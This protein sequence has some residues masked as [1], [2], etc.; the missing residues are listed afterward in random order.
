[1]TDYINLG[2]MLTAICLLAGWMVIAARV[3]YLVKMVSATVAVVLAIGIWTKSAA[4]IGYPVHSPPADGS[5]VNAIQIDDT[6]IAFWIAGVPPRSY[7]IPFDPDL[8]RRL[9]AASDFAAQTGG[10][11]I[12]H[13]H[14][15]PGHPPAG[16]PHAGGTRFEDNS[17][18]IS[19]Q[20]VPAIPEK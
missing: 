12:F 3:H 20:V 2:I 1:M 11:M 14:G 16:K 6:E 15:Q 7:V 17:P 18:P 9:K 19:I 5:V 4:L 8:A 13:L 10:K